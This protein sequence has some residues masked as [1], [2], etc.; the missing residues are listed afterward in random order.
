MANGTMCYIDRFIVHPDHRNTGVAK[1]LRTKMYEELKHRGV[2]H[3]LGFIRQGRSHDPSALNALKMSL[4]TDG[5]SYT[6][7]Q[8]NINFMI[9]EL[10]K[11][12]A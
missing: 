2:K 11:K 5:A 6:L 3:V 4:G 9:S 1:E 7:V 10:E 12:G 8:G